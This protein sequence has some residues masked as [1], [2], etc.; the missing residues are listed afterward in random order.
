MRDYLCCAVWGLSGFGQVQW[1]PTQ[2]HLM[3]TSPTP[4]MGGIRSN[5]FIN[6]GTTTMSDFYRYYEYWPY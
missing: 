4:V 2:A 1:A 5:K 3:G 6:T